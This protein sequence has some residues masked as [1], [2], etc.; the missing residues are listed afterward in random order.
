MT[1]R[2]VLLKSRLDVIFPGVK[3]DTRKIHFAL[4]DVLPKNSRDSFV[5]KFQNGP[6]YGI[7]KGFGRIL[8]G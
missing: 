3:T 8:S 4:L 7:L 2:Q 1:Q 5:L 6:Q